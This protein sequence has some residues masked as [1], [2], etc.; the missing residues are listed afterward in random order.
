MKMKNNKT[1]KRH[2]KSFSKLFMPS[3]KKQKIKH[4]GVH[5]TIPDTVLHNL[6]YH[7]PKKFS[8]EVLFAKCIVKSN[9]HTDS[10]FDINEKPVNSIKVMSVDNSV[11]VIEIMNLSNSNLKLFPKQIENMPLLKSLYLDNNSILLI[12]DTIRKLPM[13]E[14]LSLSNNKIQTFNKFLG[15]LKNLKNL[16]LTDNL[17]TEFPDWLCNDLSQLNILY[18]HGNVTIPSLPLTFKSMKSLNKFGFDWI[19][20]TKYK[21]K[22]ILNNRDQIVKLQKLCIKYQLEGSKYKPIFLS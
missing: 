7:G 2:I 14:T 16:I 5:S 8:C 1:S 17:L 15:T 12:P 22:T 21:N 19:Y 9:V 13:L 20:Y 3:I 10:E 6:P 4:K 11:K 18:I